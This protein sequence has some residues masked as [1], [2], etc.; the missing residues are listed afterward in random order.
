MYDE[1]NNSYVDNT[2]KDNT[3]SNNVFFNREIRLGFIRKV[4]IL[5]FIQ[6]LVTTGTSAAFMYSNTVRTFAISQAGQAIMILSFVI[7]FATMITLWCYINQFRKI[8]KSHFTR[9]KLSY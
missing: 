9:Y 5:L 7:M 8:I 1:E 6:L 3:Q 2:C 4:Y